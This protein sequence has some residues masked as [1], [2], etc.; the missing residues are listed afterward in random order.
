[1]K[2][3]FDGIVEYKTFSIRALVDTEAE[4][5]IKKKGNYTTGIFAKG[6]L[7]TSIAGDE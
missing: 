5:K 6:Q 3:W 1:L 7:P 4:V 2:I